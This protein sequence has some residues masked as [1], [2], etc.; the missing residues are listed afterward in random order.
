MK[1]EIRLPYP[2]LSVKIEKEEIAENYIYNLLFVAD[3]ILSEL[4]VEEIT[5]ENV[6]EIVRLIRRPLFHLDEVKKLL[7]PEKEER[8]GPAPEPEEKPEPEETE[9]EETPEEVEER[10]EEVS[11]EGVFLSKPAITSIFD[12]PLVDDEERVARLLYQDL[13]RMVIEYAKEEGDVSSA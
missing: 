5:E 4:G 6:G 1:R 11:E 13:I 8:E 3:T 10:R 7:E 2:Y 12:Y 9:P